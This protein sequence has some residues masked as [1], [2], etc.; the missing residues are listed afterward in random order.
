MNTKSKNSLDE[1]FQEMS[2]EQDMVEDQQ[3]KQNDKEM[4]K[5]NMLDA[6][7]VAKENQLKN[8]LSQLS[9]VELLNTLRAQD[10]QSDLD[11]KVITETKGVKFEDQDEDIEVDNTNKQEPYQANID[12]DYL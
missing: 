2:D 6:L 5:L 7:N 11:S 9:G 3:Y 1:M 10:E 12:F 4:K 8:D